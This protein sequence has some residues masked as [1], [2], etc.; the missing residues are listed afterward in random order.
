MVRTDEVL[1]LYIEQTHFDQPS[2]R[3]FYVKVNTEEPGKIVV[4]RWFDIWAAAV[5]INTMCVP[6][7]AAGIAIVANNLEVR[8]DRRYNP[9]DQ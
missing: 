1:P 3:G 5:A 8:L 9:L 2:Q 4:A 6:Y 7:G